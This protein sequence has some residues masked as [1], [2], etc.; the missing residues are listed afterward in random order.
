MS[1]RRSP[2]NQRKN[3]TPAAIPSVTLPNTISTAPAIV[4]SM[5]AVNPA[6]SRG[7]CV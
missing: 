6:I 3:T 7:A 1:E 5:S 2:P 4:W